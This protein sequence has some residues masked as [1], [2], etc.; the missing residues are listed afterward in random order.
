MLSYGGVWL[1]IVYA[2]INYKSIKL[3]DMHSDV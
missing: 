1:N 3:G 2:Q